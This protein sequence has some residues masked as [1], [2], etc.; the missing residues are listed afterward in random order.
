MPVPPPTPKKQIPPLWRLCASWLLRGPGLWLAQPRHAL[1]V[2]RL[3]LAL[4]VLA[5]PWCAPAA[6]HRALVWLLT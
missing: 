2:D 6:L 3:T 5:P 1:R 4:P